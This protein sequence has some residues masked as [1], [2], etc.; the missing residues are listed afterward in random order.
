[1]QNPHIIVGKGAR[2]LCGLYQVGAREKPISC[3]DII[4]A[5]KQL[6]EDG[7]NEG[8][9]IFTVLREL[10]EAD[11]LLSEPLATSDKPTPIA[12]S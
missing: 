11:A 3:A 5:S 4:D 2:C 1:M 6:H 9:L 8:V 12:K 7:T 10:I